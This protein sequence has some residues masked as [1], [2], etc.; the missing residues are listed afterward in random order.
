MGIQRAAT[1]YPVNTTTVD[2]GTG[3]DIRLLD[4]AQAGADDD[5]Q[6]ATATHTQD[7]VERTFDPATGGV[8]NTNNAGTTLFK[9]GWALRLSED[10]TPADDTNCNAFL[11]TGNFVLNLQVAVN[12]SG[13]TYASGTYAPLWKMSIW[14]YDP[15]TN[16]GTAIGGTSN[17]SLSWNIAPVGGDLGTF[18]NIGLTI[19]SAVFFPNGVEFA[20]G[21][22]L[23]LQIGLNTQT[24]PNPTVGTAT[25][26]YTLRVDNANTNITFIS[27]Q[28]IRAACAL[29]NSLVGVGV[30]TRSV[31]SE[32]ARTADGR[33]IVTRGASSLAL[34]RNAIGV[35]TISR[36]L[37]LALERS[38]V[39]AGTVT[40]T[41]AGALARS[42]SGSGVVMRTLALALERSADGRGAISSSK[43]TDASKSFDLIGTGTITEVHPVQAYRT[44]SLT[45]NGVVSGRIEIPIDEV[46]EGG[47][48]TTVVRRKIIVYDKV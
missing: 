27:G 17:N 11:T 18:K 23:L 44:F 33:G 5:T 1:L 29:S 43:A 32:I 34:S 30:P 21:E 39:G 6:T 42:A 13:G 38:A 16:T 28:G 45:G 15:A 10:M 3:I 7:N 24:I 20:Q 41:L 2:T 31:L 19:N 47:G 48:G 8:T 4:S 26:T 40:R 22:V 46:P 9:T 35:G 12:Q 25:W 14:R 36:V 37:A